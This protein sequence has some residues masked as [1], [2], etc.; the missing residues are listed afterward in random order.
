MILLLAWFNIIYSW[1]SIFSLLVLVLLYNCVSISFYSYYVRRLII[2]LE[3][4]SLSAPVRELVLLGVLN[5]ILHCLFLVRIL[6]LGREIWAKVGTQSPEVGLLE[7]IFVATIKQHF[8]DVSFCSCVH[9]GLRHVLFADLGLIRSAFLIG[10]VVRLSFLTNIR[11]LILDVFALLTEW[12]SLLGLEVEGGYWFRYWF[13]IY[14]LWS[15][16]ILFGNSTVRDGCTVDIVWFYCL[17]SILKVTV[18]I[19]WSEW[20][21]HERL[22]VSDLSFILSSKSIYGI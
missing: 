18:G 12:F 10:V 9:G 13:F 22:R 21:R 2:T 7:C 19:L 16:F 15:V 17:C 14:I 11:R 5:E 1:F 6:A 20:R 3:T 4:Y 8:R